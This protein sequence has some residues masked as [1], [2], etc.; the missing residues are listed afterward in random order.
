[1]KPQQRKIRRVLVTGGHLAPALA[2]IEELE[3][4]GG[5]EIFWVGRKFAMEREDVPSL[6]YEVIPALGIPFFN[7]RTGRLD[8]RFNFNTILNL[9][10]VLPG[11]W[12]AIGIVRKVRPDVVVSFG[13]YLSLPVVL[14]ARLMRIPVVLHEQTVVSGLANRLTSRLAAKIAIS[15]ES[16]A[17]FFPKEKV[18]FTGLPIRKS[19][20]NIV[21]HKG[22]PV[23][24]ITGGGQGSQIINKTFKD[25]M[26]EVLRDSSVIHQTGFLDYQEFLPFAKK[27]KNRYKAA[28]T[29]HP[30]EVGEI[31]KRATLIVSRSGANTVSEIAAVGIPAILIP[32]PWSEQGEQERNA[33]LLGNVGLAKVLEQDSLTPETLMREIQDISRRKL[34]KETILAARRLVNP[35]AAALFCDLIEK[36]ALS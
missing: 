9:L 31:Y 34:E 36:Y 33:R 27:Y 7:L 35:N 3:K 28:A 14:S 19:V 17:V 12:Q 23:I 5:W 32:I 4:R 6:E 1:M 16:S 10:R 22:A 24:Y 29:F 8:R 11:F 2:V 21:R 18:V 25:V 30:D 15:F 13:G 20:L 26:E